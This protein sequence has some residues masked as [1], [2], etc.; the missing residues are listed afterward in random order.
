[1]LEARGAKQGRDQVTSAGCIVDGWRGGREV[2]RRKIRRM[3]TV[4]ISEKW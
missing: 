4:T 1:V 2:T 3:V